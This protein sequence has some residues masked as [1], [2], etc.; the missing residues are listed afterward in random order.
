M[1]C[2]D[3]YAKRNTNSRHAIKPQ[4][5]WP[6]LKQVKALYVQYTISF[7]SLKSEIIAQHVHYAE[8]MFFNLF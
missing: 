7:P 1:I 8:L 2:E 6:I 4:Q 3:L 5:L